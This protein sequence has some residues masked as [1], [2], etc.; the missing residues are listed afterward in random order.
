MDKYKQSESI[1]TTLCGVVYITLDSGAYLNSDIA[2]L[3]KVSRAHNFKNMGMLSGIFQLVLEGPSESVESRSLHFV[4]ELMSV[5]GKRGG[6]VWTIQE[7]LIGC[8]GDENWSNYGVL[9]P[10]LQ[11]V[12]YA[13]AT[14]YPGQKARI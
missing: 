14:Q 6:A 12:L 8:W 2:F 11:K 5:I 3:A 13:L 9:V 1:K 7:C 10:N 4:D